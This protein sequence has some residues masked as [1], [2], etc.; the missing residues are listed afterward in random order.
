MKGT[1]SPRRTYENT[2]VANQVTSVAGGAS[3]VVHGI[4]ISNLTGG[5]LEVAVRTADGNQTTLFY[6]ESDRGELFSV[7]TPF[8]ADKGIE[9]LNVSGGDLQITVFHSNPGA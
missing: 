6:I 1:F 5:N 3:V 4:E 2:T 7:S 8:L 9:F